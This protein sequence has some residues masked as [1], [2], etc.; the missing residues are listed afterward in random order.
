M[1]RFLLL[2][3]VTEFVRALPDQF[4]ASCHNRCQC[5]K[6][7]IVCDGSAFQSTD[8][9]LFMRAEVYEDLDTVIVTGN[10]LHDIDKSNLFGE[11]VTHAHLSLLNISYNNIRSI[12]ADSLGNLPRLEVLDLSHNRL[13][14]I[15]GDLLGRFPLLHK[16]FLDNA[17]SVALN[18]SPDA[19]NMVYRLFHESANRFAQLEEIRL[20]ANLLT[21]LP[22]ETFCKL[23]SL[24][25][26]SLK[27]NRLT[28]FRFDQNCF[29]VLNRLDLGRNRLQYVSTD[30]VNVWD[31]G[32]PVMEE[33]DVSENPFICDCHMKDFI[34]FLWKEKDVFIHRDDTFCMTAKPSD[35]TN[36]PLFQVDADQLRCAADIDT[37]LHSVYLLVALALIGLLLVVACFFYRSGTNL[38]TKTL[39]GGAS[40]YTV[41]GGYH[42]LNGADQ[43]GSVRAEFV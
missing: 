37:N 17:F 42:K 14:T 16:V 28:S 39:S 3:F 35:F 41:V 25:T 32:F 19:V 38:L 27:D 30:S 31:A 22:P 11:G 15:N 8:I 13:E 7:T 5:N 34:K 36:E 43:E 23:P 10:K 21:S 1:K 9:F 12:H 4:T 6:T 33:L 24:T 20:D 18:G 26:L 29:P 2:L 40:K